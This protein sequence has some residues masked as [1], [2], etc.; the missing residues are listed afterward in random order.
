MKNGLIKLTAGI[1]TASMCVSVIPQMMGNGAVLADTAKNQ[2]NTYLGTSVIAGPDAPK[3]KDSAWSGSYVYFGAYC[4]FDGYEDSPIRFRVLSPDTSAFGGKTLFLDGDECIFWERFDKQGKNNWEESGIR[5]RLNGDF[6]DE[7]FT[8][9]EKSVI[10]V[11][12]TSEEQY[13]AGSYNE[14][15]YGKKTAL[16]GEYVFLLDAGDVTNPEYGYSNDVGWLNSDDNWGTVETGSSEPY[17]SIPNRAKIYPDGNQAFWWIRSSSEAQQG[18]AGQISKYGYMGNSAPTNRGTGV[19]PALNVDLNYVLFSTVVSGTAGKTGA[20]YKLTVTDGQLTLGL[21][22]SANEG[23][24][25][26]SK[27]TIPYQITGTNAGN[28]TRVSVLILDKEYEKGNTNDAK[29]LYYDSI[30]GTSGTGTFDLPSSLSYSSWNSDYY[31]YL[32]AEDINGEHETDYASEPVLMPAP[33]F[34]GR[35]V[36]V[37]DGNVWH[38]YD[39]NGSKVTGWKEI[40]KTW[41]FF[42]SEGNMLEGWQQDGNTW[43]F[44]GGNGAMRTGWQQLGN[45]WYYFGGNGAMCTGWHLVGGVWYYFVGSG[46][47]KTGWHQ[48]GKTWYYFS[49]SGAMKTGWQEVNGKWYYFEGSGA[50]YTGW[51]YSGGEWYYLKASGDMTTGWLL[52]NGRWYYFYN[53]GAMAY[54][55]TIDGYVLDNSGAMVE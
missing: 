34:G 35:N 29:I 4:E 28:A 14:Y 2:N 26:G 23:T 20:E 44:L 15:S 50:M 22:A 7:A 8:D 37:Q 13:S 32:L 21:A 36:W 51:R 55:T 38:Y 30:G 45:V 10:A 48:D 12:V 16:S 1:L 46:A 42:D 6:L 19:A 25:N 41:Y 43:Y 9:Q 17:Y 27:V 39:S 49:G 5:S 54:N 40:D 24:I 33:V 53:S 52:I 3:D 18:N 47:M 11:S 31:V